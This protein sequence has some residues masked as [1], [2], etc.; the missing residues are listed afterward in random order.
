MINPE[1]LHPA[2]IIGGILFS[3]MG[4]FVLFLWAV[5]FTRDNYKRDNTMQW[6][7]I[8][9]LLM[10]PPLFAPFFDSAYITDKIVFA[11]GGEV[12]GGSLPCGFL[13]MTMKGF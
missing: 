13:V 7:G 6:V 5:L 11:L 4:F 12:I 8:I 2:Y 9:C 3:L 1:Y 10:M